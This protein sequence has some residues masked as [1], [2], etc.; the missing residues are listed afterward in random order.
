MFPCL[1][2]DHTIVKIAIEIRERYQNSYW[3]GAIIVD[4]EALG[5]MTLFIENLNI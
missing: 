3:D 1:A 5:A 2:V 4:A